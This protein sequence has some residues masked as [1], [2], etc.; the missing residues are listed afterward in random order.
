MIYHWSREKINLSIFYVQ[1]YLPATFAMERPSPME[2]YAKDIMAA[3]IESHE[4]LWKFCI[5]LRTT[6]MQAKIIMNG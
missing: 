1:L 5:W 2:E 3:R 6:W 4:S